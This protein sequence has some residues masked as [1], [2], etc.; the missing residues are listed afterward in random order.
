MC[1]GN[2]P[3]RFLG[4][5]E[6]LRL[7]VLAK[8]LPTAFV[9]CVVVV[10]GA[11]YW[12]DA[13]NR[14]I[15]KTCPE[16]TPASTRCDT[17]WYGLSNPLSA[18]L[19]VGPGESWELA[20]LAIALTFL[21]FFLH[22]V[23]ADRM[24]LK[25]I[26]RRRNTDP[27]ATP[28]TAGSLPGV[29]TI[30]GD[31]PH[32]ATE[33]QPPA[34]PPEGEIHPPGATRDDEHGLRPTFR[35]RVRDVLG[36]TA[37][38]FMPA[39]L[40]FG[41]LIQHGY[42]DAAAFSI[43]LAAIYVSAEHYSSL[44]QQ[45]K[46]VHEQERDL[47]KIKVDTE[48]QVL[49]LGDLNNL[50]A[51]KVGSIENALGTQHGTDTIYEAYSRRPAAAGG[52]GVAAS[53]ENRD[54]HA[55]YRYFTI[56]RDWW[57]VSGWDAYRD[58]AQGTLYSAMLNGERRKVVIVASLKW[59]QATGMD[60]GQLMGLIWHWTV[61]WYVRAKLLEMD[62]TLPVEYSIRVARTEQWLHVVGDS[63][64]Q[65]FGKSPEE[66]KVRS[67]TFDLKESGSALADWARKE[68]NEVAMRG[69]T[70]PEFIFARLLAA[71]SELTCDAN[72]RL[73]PN[74]TDGLLS[75][76]GI[77]EWLVTRAPDRY[78]DAGAHSR[79]RARCGELVRHFVQ[80]ATDQAP[81][82]RGEE[83]LVPLHLL[84]SEVE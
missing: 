83:F 45:R 44:E 50:L 47:G 79:C 14:S 16:L 74:M 35:E 70:A 34:P 36:L 55:I 57:E 2:E 52:E 8:L 58:R 1:T 63:V 32:P 51:E 11:L 7:R 64:F 24:Q 43:A 3:R 61:L 84:A 9:W 53:S 66:V 18:D 71:D 4:L 12:R 10:G 60:F 67:L 33:Q 54:I 19:H 30:P 39:A 27:V 46:L 25:A 80:L 31:R 73:S 82:A 20:G 17:V 22:K 38:W 72:Q 13:L 56:D 65:I 68:L 42:H 41:G 5:I 76:L 62:A 23:R 40:F 75:A 26:A 48:R 69:A 77:D 81:E 37:V 49:R 28:Q 6:R 21:A 15:L 78:K 59:P 29:P